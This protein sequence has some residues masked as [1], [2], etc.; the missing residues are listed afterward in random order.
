MYVNYDIIYGKASLEGQRPMKV[1]V[2]RIRHEPIFIGECETRLE[3]KKIYTDQLKKQHEK[4]D[5]MRKEKI[6]EFNITY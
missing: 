4:Q 5:V 1:R 2:I 6:C 3:C